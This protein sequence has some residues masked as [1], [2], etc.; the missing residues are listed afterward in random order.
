MEPGSTAARVALWRALHVE[1][2]PPPHVLKDGIG[3]KLL[4]PGDGW[5]RRGDMQPQRTCRNRASI[6]ARGRFIEDLVEEE[7]GLCVAQY[8]IL[9]AGLDTF[10]QRSPEFASRLMV[11]EI[12]QPGTQ[13]WK[14][15]RLVELGYGVP[16]WLRFVPT[17]FEG[18][19]SWL[20]AL[21]VAGCPGS[22]RIRQG[23][24][25]G[26][27]LHR[28]EHVHHQGGDACYASRD[29]GPG[30]QLDARHDVHAAVGI[31]R[32]R[33]T[34]GAEGG[35]ERRQGRA[36]HLSSASLPPPN[37]WR[38]PAKRAS[39]TSVTS[40]LA[41]LPSN[42]SQTERMGCGHRAGRNCWSRRPDDGDA[43]QAATKVARFFAHPG[44]R[45]R[46]PARPARVF[47]VKR[48]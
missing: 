42:I 45:R 15:N 8:V 10:V 20:D 22:R 47:A 35:N 17:D 9:G 43:D 36:E 14:R 25:R 11:F 21:V 7:A 32:S 30:G 1:V 12:D 48:S 19:G 29:R 18:S 13:M 2:D 38:W 46:R 40:Q 41:N 5:R 24:S 27:R 16:D 26:H 39:R 23:P 33:R 34:S 3:L 4:S 44:S 28:G 37:Y 31:D 6:V